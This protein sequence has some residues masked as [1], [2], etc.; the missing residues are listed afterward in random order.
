MWRIATA[1]TFTFLGLGAVSASAQT[2]PTSPTPV[3]ATF[4]RSTP[5]TVSGFFGRAGGATAVAARLL[6]FDADGDVRVTSAELP[7]RMQSV[8]DRLDQDDDGFLTPDE[9]QAGVNRQPRVVPDRSIALRNRSASSLTEVVHDLKLP[10]P[11]HDLALAIVKNYQVPR[12]LN[13]SKS[14]NVD[15][16]AAMKELLDEEEFGDFMAAA[17]RL[18]PRSFSVITTAEQFRVQPG[19]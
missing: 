11:K 4:V 7:E 6:S 17:A 16:D 13:N 18:S 9:I 3:P 12:N 10:Q 2:L 19:R 1:V 8:F 14:I 5:D 15:V